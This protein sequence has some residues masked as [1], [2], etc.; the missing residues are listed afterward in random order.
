M[1]SSESITSTFL[2]YFSIVPRSNVEATLLV[3][4]QGRFATQP[5]NKPVYSY[6]HI[7]KRSCVICNK[8]SP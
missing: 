3:V 2:I 4:S 6:P 8:P 7:K 5:I 1:I